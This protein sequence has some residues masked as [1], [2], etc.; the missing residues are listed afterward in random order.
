MTIIFN[1][2]TAPIVPK[3]SLFI[4]FTDL[5]LIKT[6]PHA[7]HSSGTYG[8]YKVIFNHLEFD[9]KEYPDTLHSCSI[10]ICL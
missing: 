2:G 1:T 5:L 4:I 9:I 8:R 7:K 10:K 6:L 3:Q